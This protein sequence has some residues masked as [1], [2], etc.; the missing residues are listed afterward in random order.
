VP[1]LIEFLKYDQ[2]TFHNLQEPL[3]YYTVKENFGYKHAKHNLLVKVDNLKKRGLL[4]KYSPQLLYDVAN[5]IRKV[6]LR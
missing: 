1:S 3:L 2:V 4:L 5:F 6:I